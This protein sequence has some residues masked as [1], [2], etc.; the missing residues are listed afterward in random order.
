[1]RY[2]ITGMGGDIGTGVALRID[3][4]PSAQLMGIDMEPPRRRLL[5]AE[6]HRVPPED[7]KTRVGLVRAFDPEVI[8]HLGIYE[9]HSRS[10]PAD[11]AARTRAVTRSVFA[12]AADCPS[13]RKVVMRSGIE[14]YG[15]GR[16]TPLRPDEQAPLMPTTR[17]GRTLVVAEDVATGLA[18]SSGVA[19]TVLRFAPIVGP[20]IPSPLGRLLRLPVVPFAAPIDGPIQ[21][22]HIDDVHDAI[23]VAARSDVSGVFNVVGDGAVTGSQAAR[24]GGRLIVPV[25]GPGWLLAR[26][27]TAA[28]GSPLPEHVIEA[29]RRGQTA[30]GSRIRR[31]LGFAPARTTR[32]CVTDLYE[33][34]SIVRLE[35]SREIAA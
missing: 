23:V 27:V 12:A 33:W 3:G 16:G 31:E 19:L 11:A 22:I 29:M 26:V 30:D 1:M 4:D 18:A 13:L 35:P 28:L 21:L 2:L 14:V 32:E 9:P 15:R 8:I 25:F 24:I 10:N 6:F 34:A 5:R 17:F 7:D 20:Y